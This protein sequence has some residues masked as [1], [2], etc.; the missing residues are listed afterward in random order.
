MTTLKPSLTEQ[1]ILQLQ[2]ELAAAR[3]QI[4]QER[5]WREAVLNE[6]IAAHIYSKEHE[7]NP[8]KAVQDAIIWNCQVALDPA[9]SSDA[10]ALIAQE[11]ERAEA[12]A[13]DAERWKTYL[14]IYDSEELTAAEWKGAA[15]IIEHIDAA[16][17]GEKK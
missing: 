16:I 10:Q 8:R 1:T 13:R 17:A 9:V 7:T 5:E 4:A 3:E 2:R 12:N 15:A 14:K 6:L 11:R